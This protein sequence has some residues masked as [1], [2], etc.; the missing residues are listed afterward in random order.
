M[1]TKKTTQPN[2]SWWDE[3]TTVAA[4]QRL[5]AYRNAS[6]NR[7]QISIFHVPDSAVEQPPTPIFHPKIYVFS[8]DDSGALFVGSHNLTRSG[9]SRNMEAS[10]EIRGQ[11]E[12]YSEI[13]DSIAFI[14]QLGGWVV[15]HGAGGFNALWAVEINSIEDLQVFIGAHPGP[16]PPTPAVLRGGGG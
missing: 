1:R 11:K 2:R 4:I 7:V 13:N 3:V 9:L 14:N 10:L 16:V 12:D 8:N 6:N 15:P 5:L